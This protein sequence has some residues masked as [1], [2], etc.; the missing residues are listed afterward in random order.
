MLAVIKSLKLDHPVLA[1][2]S[3]AG[4]EL[5]SLGSRYSELVAGLIYL[6][7]GYSY[8][9]YRPDK[10]NL[11]IDANELQSKLDKLISL[12]GPELMG[13]TDPAV[14]EMIQELLEINLP[15]LERDLRPWQRTFKALP[16]FAATDVQQT[17]FRRDPQRCKTERQNWGSGTCD[18]CHAP[19]LAHHGRRREGRGYARS[20]SRLG[21]D[22]RG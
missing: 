10:G 16:R 8:A 19:Y 5:T 18:L 17:N 14:G 11:L 1:G 12:N 15:Q 13:P 22:S 4:V 2:W 9:Y 7:A 20:R 6:D 3:I 21:F